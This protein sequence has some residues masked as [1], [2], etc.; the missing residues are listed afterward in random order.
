MLRKFL[1]LPFALFTFINADAQDSTG[2]PFKLSGSAD[3][4][5]RYN[6]H[7]VNERP[8]NNFTSFTNSHNSIELGMLSLKAE[9]TYKKVGI[10]ADLGFGK[11]AEEFSYNDANSRLSI[12][13]LYFTYAPSNKIKFA[14]GSW[15]THVGYELVDAYLNR[16]YS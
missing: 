14:M 10:V 6:F 7:D 16:N 9:H 15:A 3:V 2:L 1:T 11:R 13:Q 12:K 4:Y 5:Y 8:F